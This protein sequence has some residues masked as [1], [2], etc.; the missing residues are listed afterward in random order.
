MFQGFG[1]TATGAV[2]YSEISNIAS[3]A[4][5]S[6][7]FELLLFVTNMEL[8]LASLIGGSYG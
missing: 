5:K 1:S 3:P 6:S 4:E 2:G 7:I 8:V